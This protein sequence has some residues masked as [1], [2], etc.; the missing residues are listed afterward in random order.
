MDFITQYLRRY[1]LLEQFESLEIQT[2]AEFLIY[3][4]IFGKEE[5]KLDTKRTVLLV[6]IC[7]KVMRFNNCRYDVNCEP[8][9]KSMEADWGFFSQL[10]EIHFLGEHKHFNREEARTLLQYFDSLYFQH[11][12]LFD[13]VFNNHQQREEINISIF[14]DQPL[15]VSPLHQALYMGKKKIELRLDDSEAEEQEIWES[16]RK[17][18]E[19]KQQA[20]LAE[21]EHKTPKADEQQHLETHFIEQQLLQV[22]LHQ[23]DTMRQH[24]ET[25]DKQLGK[26]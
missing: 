20:S 2:T 10:V 21:E 4:M 5:M 26:K 6:N 13:F 11:H 22:E 8:G 25:F 23:K 7:W 24:D 16:M 15:E 9:V 14:I 17:R 18:E 3:I 19:E 1:R 12:R